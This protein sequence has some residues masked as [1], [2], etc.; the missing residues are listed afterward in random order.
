MR[1]NSPASN[2]LL[3]FPTR[4]TTGENM[5]GGTLITEYKQYVRNETESESTIHVRNYFIDTLAAEVD[6]TTATVAELDTWL[7]AHGWAASSMNV[8]L[9]VLRHF[10]RWAN[11]YGHLTTNPALDLRRP[12]I[13]RKMGRIADDQQIRFG[14]HRAPI[15]TRLMILLGAECG[16]RRAEIARAHWDDIDGDW[17]HITGKGGHQREVKLSRALLDLLDLYPIRHGY[18]FPGKF[19]GHMTP[20]TIYQRIRRATGVNPHALRH[21]AGTTVYRNTGNNLRI[22]QEFL[23]HANPNMTA[24]YVHVSRDD[25]A[26]ASEAATLAA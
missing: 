9:S 24:K 1:H 19:G 12:R 23:G 13:P 21:R 20:D 26:F 5:T 18:L 25:L 7:H 17:L 16:L 11:R 22:A 15:D 4:Q 8:A 14:V 10:Y 6:V 3:P 2:S